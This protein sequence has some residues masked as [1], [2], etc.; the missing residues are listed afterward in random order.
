[1]ISKVYIVPFHSAV[2][3]KRTY[4][5]GEAF[6]FFDYNSS[7]NPVSLLREHKDSANFSD[8]LTLEPISRDEVPANILEMA[9]DTNVYGSVPSDRLK[10]AIRIAPK[11]ASNLAHVVR[12]RDTEA[13]TS[14]IDGTPSQ[15]RANEITAGNL[16]T[17]LSMLNQEI[18]GAGPVRPFQAVVFYLDRKGNAE[19]YL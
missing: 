4:P 8:T 15:A 13:H 2:M 14:E 11:M 10:D 7:S 17:L 5:I 18:I 12:A 16:T 6:A 3:T 1:M 19:R 9:Q